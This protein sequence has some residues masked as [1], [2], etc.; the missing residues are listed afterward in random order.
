ME[1]QLRFDG[2]RQQ[3]YL[4]DRRAALRYITQIARQNRD[5]RFELWREAEPVVLA[6]GRSGGRR[7][8][9]V[10]TLDV[11]Q[12]GVLDAIRSELDGDPP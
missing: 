2:G 11:A 9:F 10:E 5:P 4:P 12:A 3:R 8:A 7:F 1:W 6:D